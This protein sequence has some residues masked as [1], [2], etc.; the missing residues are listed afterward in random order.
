[1]F[2]WVS[3]VRFVMSVSC[4]ICLMIDLVRARSFY[5]TRRLSFC[6]R[7]SVSAF[8]IELEFV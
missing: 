6:C 7:A 1:M 2:I 5:R 8:T 4:G 3:L